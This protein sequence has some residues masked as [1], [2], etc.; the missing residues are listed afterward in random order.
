MEALDNVQLETRRMT[1]DL[2][3]RML[4]PGDLLVFDRQ[5]RTLHSAV[6]GA[7]S[8]TLTGNLDLDPLI[9][10]ERGGVRVVMQL[11]PDLIATT[12]AFTDFGAGTIRLAG[13]CLIKRRMSPDE[14]PTLQRRARKQF[15]ASPLLLGIAKWDERDD[16]L[17]ERRVFEGYDPDTGETLWLGPWNLRQGN[18]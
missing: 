8:A 7:T 17:S 10:L 5:V 2:D 16:D 3:L 6:P 4:Q 11:D 13:L 18:D 12:S 9:Y 1:R 15:L 14:P